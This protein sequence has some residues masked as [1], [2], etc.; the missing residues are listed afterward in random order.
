MVAE[1]GLIAA[2]DAETQLPPDREVRLVVDT[3]N[4]TL[5]VLSGSEV[6]GIFPVAVGKPATP[7]P[8]GEWKIIDKDYNWGGAFGARWLGLNISWGRYGIHGTN[9]P[10]SIGSNASLGCM[11]M[12][13]EDILKFFDL[14]KVGTPVDITGSPHKTNLW[15]RTLGTGMNGPDVVYVQLALKR[16]GFYPYRSDGIFGRLTDLGVRCFQSLEGLPV[17]GRV[18]KKTDQLLL[19]ED[20]AQPEDSFLN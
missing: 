14:V 12:H 1:A 8:I 2:Q 13:D 20:R 3:D 10:W 4:R 5:T 15:H 19:E 18:D 7:T 11:R 6:V 17:T 16:K 9:Q